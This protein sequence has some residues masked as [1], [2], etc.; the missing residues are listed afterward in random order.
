MVAD[1]IS[2][3]LRSTSREGLNMTEE[4]FSNLNQVIKTAWIKDKVFTISLKQ[5]K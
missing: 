5:N 3:T 4:E 2:T 1:K